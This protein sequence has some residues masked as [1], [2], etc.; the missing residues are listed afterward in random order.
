MA[1]T[2]LTSSFSYKSLLTHQKGEQ[3]L[4]NDNHLREYFMAYRRPRLIWIDADTIDLENNWGDGANISVVIFPDGNVR[5]V[6]ENT[7]VTHQYRRLKRTATASLTGTH[8]SGAGSP[9]DNTWI[10]IYAVKTSDDSSKFV[11]VGTTTL[12]LVANLATLDAA[13]GSNGWV[14]LGLVRNGDGA[15]AASGFLDFKQIGNTTLFR[16][17]VAANSNMPMTGIRLATTA[18]AT[19]LTYTYSAGTSGAVIPGNI[20]ISCYGVACE[21]MN[22]VDVSDSAGSSHYFSAG[23]GGAGTYDFCDKFWIAASEGILVSSGSS[24]PIDI[25]LIGF[26]DHVLGVG[27]NP[28]F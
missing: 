14:Y 20:L 11:L 26:I 22:T 4:A 25:F 3:L 13:Y 10:A 5:E 6:E 21:N 16:N 1:Y 7:S 23:Y 2:D 9:S 15:S 18:G 17:T 19:S 27:S 12:P 28:E 24:S 8:D